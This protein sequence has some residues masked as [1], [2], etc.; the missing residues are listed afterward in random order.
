[1]FS[2]YS[3]ISVVL[4]GRA[5]HMIEGCPG[6]TEPP[7]PLP[8]V[9]RNEKE[10]ILQSSNVYGEGDATLVRLTGVRSRWGISVVCLIEKDELGE[11]FL[12]PPVI[13]AEAR[14][15]TGGMGKIINFIFTPFWQLKYSA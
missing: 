2:E 15:W 3:S 4:G 1:M 5:S 8:C 9:L 10:Q 6:H 7:H 11:S 14:S 12:A 13:H